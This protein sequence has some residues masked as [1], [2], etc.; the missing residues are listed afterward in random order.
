[1]PT[2]EIAVVSQLENNLDPINSWMNENH[3]KLKLG[4]TE[5]I[6]FGSNVQLEK[7]I[8]TSM[9]GCGARVS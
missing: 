8:T 5:F 3:L 6:L 4:K 9:N 1:M 2:E 7:C